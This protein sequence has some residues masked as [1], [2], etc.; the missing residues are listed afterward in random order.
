MSAA[1][2]PGE[3]PRS[4][5]G[6]TGR[7]SDMAHLRARRRAARRRTRAAR[8]DLALGLAG[9]LVLLLATPGLAITGLITIV[10]LAVCII[11]LVRERRR[12]AREDQPEAPVRRSGP[13]DAL[14]AARN[15]RRAAE[16]NT[17]E[18]RTRSTR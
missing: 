16:H 5:E 3:R 8:T 9:A 7:S 13:G 1:R 10:V 15:G 14:A 6:A 17:R 12:R 11:S 4:P 18:R 2:S